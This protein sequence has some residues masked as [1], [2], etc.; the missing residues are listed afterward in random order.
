MTL[1]WI[2]LFQSTEIPGSRISTMA[3]FAI[4]SV[5]KVYAQKI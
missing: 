4:A 1:P 5:L 2:D 3:S